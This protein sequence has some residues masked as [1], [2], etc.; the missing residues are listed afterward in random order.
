MS[1]NKQCQICDR[2]YIVTN[3]KTRLSWVINKKCRDCRYI[4]DEFYFNGNYLKE[5]WHKQLNK[6][7]VSN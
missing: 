4:C 6:E 1:A 5:Y 7:I 2:K 3:S